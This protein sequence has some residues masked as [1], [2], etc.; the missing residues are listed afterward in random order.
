M[1]RDA[2]LRSARDIMTPR[3]YV[4][5]PS[6]LARE[7][8]LALSRRG[9][10]GAPV[11][12]EHDDLVGMI[13]TSDIVRT[14]ANAAFAGTPAETVGRIMTRDVVTASPESDLFQLSHL[15]ERAGVGHL[16]VVTQGRLVGLVTQKDVMRALTEVCQ[17]RCGEIIGGTI[18]SIAQLELIHNPFP[19]PRLRRPR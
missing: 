5:R 4:V 11:L 3:V 13:S 9:L 15:M 16:P 8:S 7:A 17:E 14:L 12:D 1:E 18:D 10:G 2:Q 19:A 6:M